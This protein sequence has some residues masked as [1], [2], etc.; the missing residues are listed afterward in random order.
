MSMRYLIAICALST[1]SLATAQ[2]PAPSHDY[3]LDGT[4][5]DSLGGPS[6]TPI[7]APTQ[8]PT[9]VNFFAG[10]GIALAGSAFTNPASYSV[11][12]DFRID[13]NPSPDGYG[14]IID[15]SGNDNGF[16]TFG[17]D[18]VYYEAGRQGSTPFSF[19]VPHQVIF[20]RDAT[21]ISVFVDGAA[22]FSVPANASSLLDPA[23]Q[24]RFFVD[25]GAE[26]LTGFVDRI[27]TF[28]TALTGSQANALF[29]AAVPEPG[30]WAL[31]IGGF[32]AVGVGLRRRRPTRV[33]AIA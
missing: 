30:T 15:T 28:D 1:A 24:I 13:S 29:V 6:L 3:R 23:G 10:N 2:A 5:A 16:Y 7:G 17:Q 21:G 14:R 4:L 26:N 18:L 9:G 31:L 8:T 33:R 25:D 11:A 27:R 12:L 22:G 32:G 20:A 19:G